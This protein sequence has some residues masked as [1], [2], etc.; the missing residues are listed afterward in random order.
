MAVTNLRLALMDDGRKQ[1][2][3]AR[4]ANMPPSRLSEYALG[5]VNMPHHHL[6]ALS[7]ALRRNPQDLIGDAEEVAI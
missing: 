7:V 4:L 6:M 5:R 2:E 1:R 3:I